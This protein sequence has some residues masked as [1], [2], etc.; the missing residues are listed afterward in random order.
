MAVPAFDFKTIEAIP[1]WSLYPVIFLP[2][3]GVVLVA[4][5]VWIQH[6]GDPHLNRQLKSD[7]LV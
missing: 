6:Y 5:W 3:T 2:L 1:Q 4:Y 7:G